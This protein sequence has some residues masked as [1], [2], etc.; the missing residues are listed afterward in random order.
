M[1]AEFQDVADRMIVID[2]IDGS[3]TSTQAHLVAYALERR[4]IATTLTCNPSKGAIGSML[5]DWLTGS[6]RMPAMAILHA[7]VADRW[8][9]LADQRFG[10]ERHALKNQGKHPWI[11]CD[12]F[13]LST[14]CYQGIQPDIP[15]GMVEDICRFFPKPKLTVVLDV[16]V[17]IAMARIHRRGE[18]QEQI[19]E[20]RDTLERVRAKYLHHVMADY[21]G[22]VIQADRDEYEIASEIV[23]NVLDVVEG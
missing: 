10:S 9:F 21:G 14:L 8:A 11:V 6:P 23:R 5:R 3:G 16:P 13:T 7:F 20:R 19:Y 17:E 18:V 4:G 15:P 12:R 22:I 2:G 1:T